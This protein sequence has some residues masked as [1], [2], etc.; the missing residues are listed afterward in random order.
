AYD[1]R[2]LFWVGSGKVLLW[3]YEMISGLKINYMKSEIFVI[4]GDVEI[5]TQYAELY[6]GV[7]KEILLDKDIIWNK[8][9]SNTNAHNIKTRFWEDACDLNIC[10]YDICDDKG[11]MVKKGEGK[12]LESIF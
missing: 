10:L 8:Y 12:T 11:I 1:K 4:K 5:S 7:P 6:L 9:M 2:I 3:L